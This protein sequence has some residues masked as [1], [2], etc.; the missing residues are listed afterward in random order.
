MSSLRFSFPRS[1]CPLPCHPRILPI[2]FM[3]PKFLFLTSSKS[4][5]H[6]SLL[7]TKVLSDRFHRIS[8]SSR[9]PPSPALH[10]PPL[11]KISRSVS[12]FSCQFFSFFYLFVFSCLFVCFETES[13]SITQAGVRW[14]DLG[15]LQPLP[16]G[17]K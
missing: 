15:S 14:H 4:L 17:F 11:S 12:D 8:P 16:A 1:S 10:V 3:S 5:P 13:H 7:R 6:C 2:P 9:Y